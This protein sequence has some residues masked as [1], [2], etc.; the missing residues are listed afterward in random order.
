[1][2]ERYIGSQGEIAV[3]GPENVASSGTSVN[4][5]LQV[6]T[7]QAWRIQ[8]L[9]IEGAPLSTIALKYKEETTGNQLVLGTFYAYEFP[10]RFKP[11]SSDN[12]LIIWEERTL[13]FQATNTYANTQTYRAIVQYIKSYLVKE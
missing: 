9:D 1:M 11:T 4:L 5:K 6:N 7:G 10:M 13:E 8:R 2:A 3:F 12:H